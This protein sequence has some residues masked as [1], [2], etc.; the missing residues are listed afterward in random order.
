M[1]LPENRP[2]DRVYVSAYMADVSTASSAFVTSPVRGY[3]KKIRGELYNA[4]TVADANITAEINGTAVTGIAI[5]VATAGSAAGDTYAD[6]PTSLSTSF[7]NPGDSLE[8]VSDGG[9]TTTAPMTW[10]WEIDPV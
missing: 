2:V 10:T 7:V 1:A 8:I 5:V 4:I 3:V 9:S 6:E